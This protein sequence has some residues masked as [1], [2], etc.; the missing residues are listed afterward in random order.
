MNLTQALSL[1]DGYSP[2]SSIICDECGTPV[3]ETYNWDMVETL[4][5]SCFIRAL[6]E[7][8]S[9]QLYLRWVDTAR[10]LLSLCQAYQLDGLFFPPGP[11]VDDD[12]SSFFGIEEA[13]EYNTRR[14]TMNATQTSFF[15]SPEPPR[16]PTPTR[17][18]P[19]AKPPKPVLSDTGRLDAEPV[20]VREL[21]AEERPVSRLHRYGASS[22]SNAE[23]LAAIIQTPHAL[24]TSNLLLARFNGLL[25]LIRASTAELMDVDGLGPARVAQIKAAFEL[26]RRLLLASPADRQQIRSPAEAANLM[27]MEMGLL[28]QE[29][30]RLILMDSKNYVLDTPTMY[31]GSLNTSVIRIGELFREAIKQNCAAVIVVHNHPSGDPTPSPEDVAVTGQIVQAGRLLDIDVLDH[32]IIGQ[33]RYVSMKERGLGF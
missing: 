26:G 10:E 14:Y 4:C 17:E 27:M 12:P 1:V 31:I 23:L 2:L 20:L 24:H 25:G 15:P 29:H 16:A 22:I 33:Q 30:M 18:A 3:S 28:E 11:N 7:H 9:F 19:R 5:P 21:P 13:P 32:L 6:Y 8:T